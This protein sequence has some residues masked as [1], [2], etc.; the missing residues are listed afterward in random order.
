M[1]KFQHQIFFTTHNIQ[2]FVFFK[3][4]LRHMVTSQTLELIFNQLLL[5]IIENLIYNWQGGEKR[6][7]K[8][9]KN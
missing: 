6:R 4:Q 2:H 3:F 9:K 1:T 7:R 8:S 5:Y